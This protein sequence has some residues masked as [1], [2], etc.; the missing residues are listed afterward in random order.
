MFNE[1]LIEYHSALT[2]ISQNVMINKL[3]KEGFSV[4]VLPTAYYDINDF[5]LIHEKQN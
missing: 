1:I 3:E 2:G 5:G 4:K